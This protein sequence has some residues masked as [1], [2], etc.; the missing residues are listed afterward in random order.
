MNIPAKKRLLSL[1]V[2]LNIIVWSV[3]IF[4]TPYPYQLWSVVESKSAQELTGI[5]WEKSNTMLCKMPLGDI[6]LFYPEMQTVSHIKQYIREHAL[7]Q[8]ESALIDDAGQVDAVLNV[9]AYVPIAEI[10]DTGC[11]QDSSAYQ[12]LRMT[13]AK[14]P[15][16][17][18]R[19]V[20]T[21]IK[22]MLN[23]FV[24]MEIFP[25]VPQ[26][27][28]DSMM[29]KGVM[30]VVKITYQNTAILITRSLEFNASMGL[31]SYGNALHAD[32]LLYP[33]KRTQ[34]TS[35]SM[36]FLDMVHPRQIIALDPLWRNDARLWNMSITLRSSV[37]SLGRK[38]C[39]II[40]S[41][42]KRCR[43]E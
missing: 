19:R 35:L 37:Y 23:P 27:G 6:V 25:A 24:D 12:R 5:L 17:A 33:Q 32:V 30:P 36:P 8:I 4:R 38:N 2:F 1:V 22:S 16:I 14:H 34:E 42:G 43:I 15:E 7:T 41:D 29:Q 39:V 20:E 26:R 11:A 18:Y 40:Y 31:V 21:R 10:I 13:I 28:G 3:W 9:M